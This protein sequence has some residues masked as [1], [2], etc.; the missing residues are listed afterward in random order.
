MEQTRACARFE[1]SYL[2]Y[3]AGYSNSDHTSKTLIIRK[4]PMRI[5]VCETPHEPDAVEGAWAA[6]YAHVH[7]EG[8]ELLILP[9]FAF[10]EPVWE[11]E[12]FDPM[13]WNA[14][15]QA[16]A[17]WLA[18]M[19]ELHCDHVV[20]SM[21]VTTAGKPLNRG[22]LWSVEGGL[23]PLRSK[24]H[25]PDEPG[26][27]EA[28]WFTKGTEEFSAFTAGPLKF[29]LNICTE[30]W[31]LETCGPYAQAGVH[32]VISPRA[33][34]AATTER[35]VALAKTVAVR[36]GAFSLSS[37]RRHADGTCGG[38]G[39]IID[40]EGNELVRT[41]AANPIATLDIDLTSSCNAKFIYPR[42]VFA[43]A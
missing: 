22:F 1:T 41:S 16:G 23:T 43:D 5:T 30:L 34:V 36:T 7:A 35:W 37:N 21:P 29:G 28:R 6:L 14:L 9:E 20:G 3:V 24:R 18:R 12:S 31:A 17:K 32:A 15:E 19:P 2:F 8:T 26:A 13:R 27:W 25:L 40:P 38:V 10:L 33:T 4:P 11:S 42:Y 39:W